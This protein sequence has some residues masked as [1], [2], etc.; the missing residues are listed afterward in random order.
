M[1]RTM[2]PILLA[3]TILFGCEGKTHKQAA[4]EIGAAVGAVA[5]IGVAVL[6]GSDE[7]IDAG[8]GVGFMA[9]AIVGGLIGEFIGGK[10][11]EHDAMKAELASLTALKSDDNKPVAWKSDKNENVNGEVRVIETSKSA[12]GSQCKTVNHMLNISGKEELVEQE[13]CLDSEGSWRLVAS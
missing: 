11:D 9:G 13:Y 1:K 6:T 4:G 10:L 7:G 12:S 5:G 3:S 8:M 2:I